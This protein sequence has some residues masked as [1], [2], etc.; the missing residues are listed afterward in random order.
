MIK[1]KLPKIKFED[2]EG[3]FC[4]LQNKPFP[5]FE[6]KFKNGIKAQH[7][8]SSEI[9]RLDM[10]DGSIYEINILRDTSYLGDFMCS[11]LN[12]TLEKMNLCV[13][14]EIQSK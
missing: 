5:H 3:V 13:Q 1:S 7:T 6:A 12:K 9:V 4:L 11:V 8:L 14:K 2:D 10:S